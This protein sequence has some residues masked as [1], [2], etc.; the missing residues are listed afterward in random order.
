[1]SDDARAAARKELDV[2]L[3]RVDSLPGGG[4]V[5]R[6]LFYAQ[7]FGFRALTLSLAVPAGPGPHPVVVYIH[8]GGWMQ[9]HPHSM[10]PNL[11]SINFVDHLLVAGYAVARISYRLSGEGR[12]PTQIQDCSAALRYLAHHADRFG[13]DPD[14]MAALGESAGGH[15]ALLLG[16]ETPDHFKGSE[17][18]AG[19][20]PRLR[21]VVDWYGVTD[22]KR[23]DAQAL[24]TA[25]FVHDSEVSASGRLIGGRIS[26]WP[27]AAEAAS[28][29][30]WVSAGAVPVLIQHGL[31][32]SVVPPGQGETL[33]QALVDAGAVAEWH[34][35]AHAD[36]CFVGGD[37]GAVMP[38]VLAFLDRYVR[39]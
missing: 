4:R 11:A 27:A 34:P 37:L 7:P 16:L 35:V 24:P 1:M 28:P 3:E 15:L 32:D 30:S 25:R 12:F 10:H 26:D 2:C 19:P 18:I 36:H 9:G 14:R 39:S 6:E 29:I 8:G 23:L 22:L 17:G 33:Y 21:A 31:L 20:T 13:I 5:W 38:P